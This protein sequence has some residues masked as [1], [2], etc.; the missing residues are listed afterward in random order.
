M[1]HLGGLQGYLIHLGEAILGPFINSPQVDHFNSN[2]SLSSVIHANPWSSLLMHAIRVPY[3]CIPMEFLTHAY[4][5]SSLLMHA[6][7][8]PYSCMPTQFLTL[9]PTNQNN[10]IQW[11]EMRNIVEQKI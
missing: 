8:V 11:K 6:H 3:S 9:K 5:W 1:I 10:E 4:P 2:R 7:R